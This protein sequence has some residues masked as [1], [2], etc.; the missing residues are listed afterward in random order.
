ME[1][2]DRV[3]GKIQCQKLHSLKFIWTSLP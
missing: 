2:I 3:L 1:G